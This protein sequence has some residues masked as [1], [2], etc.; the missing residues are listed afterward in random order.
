MATMRL[1]PSVALLTG[2]AF[3]TMVGT[4]AG[5]CNAELGVGGVA[6]AAADPTGDPMG[7]P[8]GDP[9]G[10]PNGMTCP[11]GFHLFGLKCVENEVTCAAEFPCP[12]G[13]QCVGGRCISAPG[14]CANND[15]CPSGFLCVGGI[16]AQDCPMKNPMC[17]KDTDCGPGE[18][19][20][21]CAC[22]SADTCKK[23]TP[24]LSGQPWTADQVLHLDQALGAFGK[25]FANILQDVRDG[26]NGCPKGSGG[27][28]WVF[29]IVSGFI[30]QWAKTL[31]VVVADFT[32][33]L[34]NNQF[35]IHSQMTFKKNG[36]PSSYDGSD[37]WLTLE[38]NYQHMK[39]VKKPEDVAQIGKPVVIPFT[40]AAI[41]GRLYVDKHKVEGVLSGILKWLLDTVVEV[42]TCANNGPCYHSLG[43]AIDKA[44]NC[45]QFLPGNPAAFAICKPFKDGIKNKI[46]DAINQWLLSYS[47]MTLKGTADVDASGAALNNGKWDGTLGS[48]G[49]LFQN[50]T[51]E[52]SAKR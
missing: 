49:G 51:G 6:P 4:M 42:S 7:D 1:L 31:I 14:P 21:A 37:H 28:C 20:L 36:K 27:N 41:C 17:T 19:C 8:N 25:L 13:Q 2:L 46:D 47:L 45:N 26:I 34:N 23:P 9:M 43:E 11:A 38:F 18:L 44:I 35:K 5:G 40:S 39:I 52:W 30:P 48:L 22:V 32:D 24:D 29:Q 50:F 3:T 15:D 12:E 33:L 10:D 16:C